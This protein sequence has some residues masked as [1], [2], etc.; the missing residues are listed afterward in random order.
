MHAFYWDKSSG[1]M[2]LL[3]HKESC[4]FWEHEPLID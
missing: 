4:I 3:K 2:V 1:V